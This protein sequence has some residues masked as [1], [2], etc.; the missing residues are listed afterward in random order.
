MTLIV[1]WSSLPTGQ[2][3][4]GTFYDAGA[5]PE[6]SI[7]AAAGAFAED[8]GGIGVFRRDV[9]THLFPKPLVRV[10][11]NELF[12]DGWV[13]GYQRDGIQE[14]KSD[15]ALVEVERLAQGLIVFQTYITAVNDVDDV[16]L[17]DGPD[18]NDGLENCIAV[19]I[20]ALDYSDRVVSPITSWN[21]GTKNL[22]IESTAWTPA[23][24]DLVLFLPV[25]A[26]DVAVSV[27]VNVP[28]TA[29]ALP[30]IGGTRLW[31]FVGET[32][33]QTLSDLDND[34]R[35]TPLKLSIKDR[36]GT[37]ILALD[38]VDLTKTINSIS[39]EVPKALHTAATDWTWS[40]RV[41]DD[42][43]NVILYGPYNVFYAP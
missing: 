39:F 13:S 19:L 11:H 25:A 35:T 12:L 40:I 1:K 6:T 21:A 18:F 8:A 10:R 20:N 22:V 14:V 7:A 23:V 15:P 42:D 5:N 2:A 33:L 4:T 34:Y 30:P 38:D 37:V 41:D 43:E 28:T 27:T 24:N 16:I 3:F 31:A 17:F 26:S 36:R 9:A 29:S 32:R